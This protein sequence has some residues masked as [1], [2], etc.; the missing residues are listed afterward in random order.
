[1]FT[2]HTPVSELKGVGVERAK[3][4]SKLGIHTLYDLLLYFPRAYEKRGDVRRLADA[5]TDDE[6]VS[7]LLT[8]ATEVSSARIRTG[9]T[10]SKFRAFD[11]SGSV[12]ITF[13][14]APFVKQVFHTG[15]HFRFFGKLTK[16]RGRLSMIAPKYEPWLQD[17]P[18]DDFVPVYPLTDGLSSKIIGGLVKIAVDALAQDLTDPLPETLRRE[19]SLPTLSYAIRNIHTPIDEGSLSQAMR[20]LA[21]DELFFFALGIAQVTKQKRTEC[22]VTVKKTSVAPFL[23]LLPYELTDDQKKAVNDIYLDMTKTDADGNTPPMTRILAGDVGSGKTV[24]AALAMYIVA[25]SSLQSA[26]MVPTEILARQ[27]YEDLA[28]M[29]SS[30]G[31]RVALL[32]GDTKEKERRLILEQTQAGEIDI[33]I[34]THALLSDRLQFKALG[35]IIT[36]EQHRFGVRQRAVLK[37]KASSAH[38]LVMSATPIPRSLAL[39]M[40][41]DLDVSRIQQMP[42]GRMRVETYTVGESY[43][44]RVLAFIEK[45]VAEGGQCYIVCP[46]IEQGE[47]E[48][49]LYVPDG[50]SGNEITYTNGQDLK[51]AVEYTADLQ[52]KLPNLRIAC[53]HGRMKSAVRD[54][55]MQDFAHGDIDV[56]VSTTV[57]EVGVNVPNAT[58]MLVENA[59]RFGLSQLHQL[60]GR[61]GRGSKRSYCILISDATSDKAKERLS[62]MRTTYDGYAIAE[63]D[64]RM[65]GPGDFFSFADEDAIRQSGGFTFRFAALSKDNALLEQA[66]GAA[67]RIVDADPTLSEPHNRLLKEHTLSLLHKTSTIS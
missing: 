21:F 9:M 30:L 67:R 24:C 18:L 43:R 59:D 61:V 41:G 38:M 29:F 8:V 53:M 27:H 57:I 40:Y 28:P 14:N 46:S 51:S 54:R 45:Q 65:R 44:T 7:L 50:F 31:Y 16:H 13:F 47:S 5:P 64:L 22:A 39:A 37:E 52:K 26:L 23:A 17:T 55:I 49:P 2:V 1:M 4:L 19:L 15:A 35:L 32:L 25:R 10:V 3:K 60:R 63:R 66:F 42:K 36:D 33:L 56:L 34:G 58:L 6:P 48:Q 12:E 20:R 62:I 11:E